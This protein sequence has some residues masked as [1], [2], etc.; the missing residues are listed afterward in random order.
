MLPKQYMQNGLL[1]LV[2]GYTRE[3]KNYKVYNL[4]GEYTIDSR[5]T[6]TLLSMNRP[7]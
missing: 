3:K 4:V 2:V 7:R 1:F 5:V 6:V